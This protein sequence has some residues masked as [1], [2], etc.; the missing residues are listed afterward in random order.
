MLAD[1]LKEEKKGGKEDKPNKNKAANAVRKDLPGFCGIKAATTNAAMAMLHQ[2]RN[3]QAA[4][5]NKM[6]S[7]KEIK[8]FI[9]LN[10]II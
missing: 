8:N 4:K 7:I 5:L 10:L 1:E 6:V 9:T 2:G 3:K